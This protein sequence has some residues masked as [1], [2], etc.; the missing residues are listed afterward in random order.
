MRLLAAKGTSGSLRVFPQTENCHTLL[1]SDGEGD[2][3]FNIVT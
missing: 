2:T 3:L 1:L